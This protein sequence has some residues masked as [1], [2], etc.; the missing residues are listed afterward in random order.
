MVK[1]YNG[2]LSVRLRIL[3]I[4][5]F[6]YILSSHIITKELLSVILVVILCSTNKYLYINTRDDNLVKL[7]I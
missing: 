3:F 4:H 1:C 7:G 6:I 5:R 2:I